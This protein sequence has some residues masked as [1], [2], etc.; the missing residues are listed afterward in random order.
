MLYFKTVP[1]PHGTKQPDV[2]KA[3]RRYS[4]KRTSSLDFKSSATNVGTDKLFLGLE[5]KNSLKFT[6]LKTSFE[7]LLPKLIISLSKDQTTAAYRIRLSAIPS[8]LCI[9][10]LFGVVSIIIGLITGNAKLE[11]VIFVVAMIIV[12]TLLLKL[13]IRL[14]LSRVSK[15]IKISDNT[16]P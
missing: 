1:F 8:A 13:E 16:L 3:L 2:E 9:L 14:L 12:F 4:L 5:G 15:C 6:R 11:G 10:L 7:V